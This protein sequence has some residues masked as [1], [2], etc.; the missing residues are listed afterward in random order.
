MELG[1]RGGGLTMMISLIVSFLVG[2]VLG[3]RFKVLILLPAITLA[4]LA[5]IGGGLARAEPTWSIVLIAIGAAV[6]LQVGYL[7]GTG[8]RSLIVGARASRAYPRSVPA[9]AVLRRTAH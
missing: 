3:Q 6:A 5:V 4:V 7:V 9:P 1:Q 2:M 8:I